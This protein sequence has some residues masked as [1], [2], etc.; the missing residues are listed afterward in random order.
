V[1]LE[2]C[3]ALG[4]RPVPANA[5]ERHAVISRGRGR[6]F[7]SVENA[8]RFVMEKLDPSDRATA[9]IQTDNRPIHLDDIQAINAG[10]K[11]NPP[12]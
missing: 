1:S 6:Q 4:G 2:V 5:P 3:G 12:G 9:M 10:M 11:Q 7:E 8:V